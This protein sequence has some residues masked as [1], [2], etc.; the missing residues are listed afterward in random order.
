MTNLASLP[1]LLRDEPALELVGGRAHAVLAV[2]EAARAIAVA[3][4]AR[5]SAADGRHPLL[6]ATAT[7]TA[8]ERLAADLAV[9]LGDDDV[10]LFPA[11]ETLPFERMSPS[12]ETM[13]RRLQG[14]VATPRSR[15]RSRS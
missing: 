4:L 2:P 13:G 12:V 6:V 5:R 14:A 9:F 7:G 10:E 8:A 15:A 1:S 3:G 11:W